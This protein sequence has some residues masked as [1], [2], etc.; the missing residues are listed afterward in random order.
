M[1]P[2]ADLYRSAAYESEVRRWCADRLDAWQ[3]PHTTRIVSTALGD[4]HLTCVGEG[5]D[6]CVY[7]PGTNF[8]AATSIG[9]LAALSEHCR[10]VCADLPGQPGLSAARRPTD[11]TQ[12]YAAWV[13]EV[14]EETRRVNGRVVLM[15][16]SRGAAAALSAE[17][18]TV[19]A[20]ILLSPAGLAR[21][22][23]TPSMLVRSVTWLL[24]PTR[25]RSARLVELMAGGAPGN[26]LDLVVEWMT[27]VARSTRTTGAPGPLAADVLDRWRGR[28][29]RVLTGERDIFFPPRRLAGPARE[30]LGEGVEIV[31]D[32]GHLLV[33]QRPDAAAA[34]LA[35]VLGR[36]GSR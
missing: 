24:R 31:P 22:R 36:H 19:H 14:I 35:A 28:Q 30:H 11:E 8:N 9:V 18:D 3:A 27:I 21:V 25:R 34:A 13:S 23:L 2:V 1:T 7:L 32:V 20:L 33:D 10:V 12:G 26:D 29:V 17:P 4:T 15:G 6:V 5:A 16:H